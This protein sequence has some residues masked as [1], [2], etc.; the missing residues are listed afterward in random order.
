MATEQRNPNIADIQKTPYFV[1]PPRSSGTQVLAEGL[2]AVAKTGAEL[3]TDKLAS[4]MAGELEADQKR[5]LDALSAA[6]GSPTADQKLAAEQLKAGDFQTVQE[7]QGIMNR[8]QNAADQGAESITALKIR[9]ENTLREYMKR[10]PHLKAHFNQA[11]TGVLGYSPLGARQRAA[12]AAIQAASTGRG[13]SGNPG[14][15]TQKIMARA[16]ALGMDT[17][18]YWTAPDEFWSEFKRWSQ[19]E[20]L[21]NDNDRQMAYQD[22][23]NASQFNTALA[24]WSEVNEKVFL[25][26]LAGGP[27]KA[28]SIESFMVRAL[29]DATSEAAKPMSPE[30]AFALVKNPD[31][32]AKGV[33]PGIAE[34]VKRNLIGYKEQ[35]LYATYN[36]VVKPRPDGMGGMKRPMSFQDFRTQHMAGIEKMWDVAVEYVGMDGLGKALEHYARMEERNWMDRID[37]AAPGFRQFGFV[38][39]M[40]GPNIDIT[41]MLSKDQLSGL[42]GQ[43]VDSIIAEMASTPTAPGMPPRVGIMQ[44]DG[45]FKPPGEGDM[46]FQTP[47][48]L[49]LRKES[50]LME[51]DRGYEHFL[52]LSPQWASAGIVNKDKNLAVFG[53]ATPLSYGQMR[54]RSHNEAARGNTEYGFQPS[55]R[56][57]LVALSM[58]ASP[59]WL[60]AYQLAYGDHPANNPAH[61][62]QVLAIGQQI[63]TSTYFEDTDRILTAIQE[64]DNEINRILRDEAVAPNFD[65]MLPVRPERMMTKTLM[66]YSEFAEGKNGN[67][68]LRM[69]PN[70]PEP[71]KVRVQ[72]LIDFANTTS[73]PSN[74]TKLMLAV[75]AVQNVTGMTVDEAAEL[76]LFEG[77]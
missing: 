26:E 33:P 27:N 45:T 25:Q 13:G 61:L 20:A 41:Q 71:F 15:E 75:K 60:E 35:A 48:E 28:G 36:E 23:L 70:T 39:Q 14:W 6:D 51:L 58:L 22:Q 38:L 43:M 21:K 53:A 52:S 64:D 11:A 32:F 5:T 50:D 57:D 74:R 34:K 46:A 65:V 62:D 4:D 30:E 56:T 31:A 55:E 1:A 29:L 2:T 69:S 7:L 9:Q 59:V 44:P 77:M 54:I 37:V 18:T 19:L 42:M 47:Q 10:Y 73:N 16:E 76:L 63:A 24:A 40:L 3:Y 67:L 66:D 8:L 72:K 68:E 12:E 49:S 17:S